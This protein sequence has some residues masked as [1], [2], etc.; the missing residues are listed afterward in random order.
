M[1]FFKLAHCADLRMSK[2][3]G[4]KWAHFAFTIKMTKFKIF[5]SSVY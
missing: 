3:F 5:K 1:E 4:A 2:K